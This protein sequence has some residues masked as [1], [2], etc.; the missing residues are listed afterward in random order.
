MHWYFAYG[1]NLDPAQ[2]ADREV[3]VADAQRAHLPGWKLTFNKVATLNA[4]QGEGRANIVPARRGAVEGVIFTVDD[5]GLANLDW[6][7]GARTGHYRQTTLN[8]TVNG[9]SSVEAI[10]YIAQ[11]TGTGLK[12]SRW[13]LAKILA[14]AR[15]FGLSPDYIAWLEGRPAI[16]PVERP[17]VRPGG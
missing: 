2:L 3:N 12:P 5:T 8:V 1:S 15:H 13:Y 9:D 17:L 6:Y 16:G 7:E 11:L 10:T 14:G 4:V